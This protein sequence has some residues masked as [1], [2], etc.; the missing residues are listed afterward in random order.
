MKN[1]EKHRMSDFSERE[2]ERVED[3]VLCEVD[4]R[5][6]GHRNELHE[7]RGVLVMASSCTRRTSAPSRS[8]P[9]SSTACA[10]STA[11]YRRICRRVGGRRSAESSASATAR[12]ARRSSRA[13]PVSGTVWRH[14]SRPSRPCAASAAHA[15]HAPPA[16]HATYA[17]TAHAHWRAPSGTS[18]TAALSCVS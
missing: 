3:S 8:S 17:H 15:P 1:T 9:R 14:L 4:Q 7:D 10:S 5:E 13:R 2:R 6:L 18:P 11:D 12:R 16:V